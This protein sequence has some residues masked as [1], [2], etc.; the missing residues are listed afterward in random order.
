MAKKYILALIGLWCSSQLAYAQGRAYVANFASNSVSVIDTSSNTVIYT[1]AV[2]TQPNGIAFTPDGT[3]AYVTNGGGDVWVLATSNNAVVAKVVVGGYPS[4]IA[5]T[6][7]GTRA[8]VTRD[9][10]NSVWVIDR[11]C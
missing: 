8:Y 6:P 9:N 10:A 2:G 4:G 1:I 3:R 11:N 7:D 5:I